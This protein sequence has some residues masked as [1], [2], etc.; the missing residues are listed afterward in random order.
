MEFLTQAVDQRV[1]YPVSPSHMLLA[2]S[3]NLPQACTED[4]KAIIL[5][6]LLLNNSFPKLWTFLCHEI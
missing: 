6:K 2:T 5:L 4:Q 3:L 1:S